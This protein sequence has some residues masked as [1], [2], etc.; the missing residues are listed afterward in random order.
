MKIYIDISNLVKPTITETTIDDKKI[1]KYNLEYINKSDINRYNNKG[2]FCYGKNQIIL[3]Y[4][5]KVMQ[6]YTTLIKKIFKIFD[7]KKYE[8]IEYFNVPEENYSAWN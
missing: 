2:L 6:Q 4:Q 3:N 7:I 5:K 1:T 8:N